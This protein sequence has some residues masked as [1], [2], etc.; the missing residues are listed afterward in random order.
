M[1]M[2]FAAGADGD[3]TPICSA[4]MTGT[5]TGTADGRLGGGY[6]GSDTCEGSFLNGTLTMT[7]K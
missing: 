4:T 3:P 7:R 6:T 2:Q 5:A 1:S